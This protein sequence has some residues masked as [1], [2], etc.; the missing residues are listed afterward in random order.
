MEAVAQLRH[1][2]GASTCGDWVE[3]DESEARDGEDVSGRREAPGVARAGRLALVSSRPPIDPCMRFSR[4]W[5]AVARSPGGIRHPKVGGQLVEQPVDAVPLDV[6]DGG[7]VD[8]GRA[9]IA[10]G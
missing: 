8:A 1:G 9:A 10:A 5:L 7:P 3:D 2:V 4:T 6:D